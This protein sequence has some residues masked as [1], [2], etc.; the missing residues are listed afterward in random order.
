MD[1][2]DPD[3]EDI[4]DISDIADYDYENEEELIDAIA[5][6]IQFMDEVK[7]YERAGAR[8]TGGGAISN[9]GLG[10]LGK[11]GKKESEDYY[12][13]QK[14][15]IYQKYKDDLKLT[16][17]FIS[18]V[19]DAYYLIN[20]PNYKNMDSLILGLWILNWDGDKGKREIIPKKIEI[21]KRLIKNDQNFT[22]EDVIRYARMWKN[23][24]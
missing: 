6:D 12:Q 18:K 20:K 7:A 14:E 16:D 5:D 13:I 10:Q 23:I 2:F 22:L 8:I 3:I 11:M 24:L 19:G 21:V 17:N 9:L 4:R 15:A 1:Y